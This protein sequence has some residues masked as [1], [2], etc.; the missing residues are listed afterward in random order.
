MGG[1]VDA[2]S[3]VHSIKII[4][5]PSAYSFSGNGSQTLCGESVS[6]DSVFLFVAVTAAKTSGMALV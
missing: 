6:G 3:R 2:V 5:R 4:V 1:N